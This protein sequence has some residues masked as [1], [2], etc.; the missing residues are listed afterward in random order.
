MT[1]MPVYAW[2]IV[3]VLV[4]LMSGAAGVAF[5]ERDFAWAASLVTGVI[6]A[7]IIIAVSF[8]ASKGW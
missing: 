6:C 7:C 2:F 4:A 5:M 8:T 3:L 1:N